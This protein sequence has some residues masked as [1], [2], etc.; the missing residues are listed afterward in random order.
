MAI[1]TIDT[2][3]KNSY[4]LK[5]FKSLLTLT[6]FIFLVFHT[7]E[8]LAYC[9]NDTSPTDQSIVLAVDIS[10][11]VDNHEMEMQMQAYEH[12]IKDP[13][14]KDKLLTCGCTEVSVVFFASASH[15]V[16]KSKKIKT[17]S[18]ISVI[19][20]LFSREKD[21]AAQLLQIYNDKGETYVTRALRASLDILIDDKNTSFRKAI[22]ISG[23]GANSR[24]ADEEFKALKKKSLLHGIEVSAVPIMIYDGPDFASPENDSNYSIL[25]RDHSTGS[26]SQFDHNSV[27]DFYQNMVVNKF[28]MMSVAD[29]YEDLKPVLSQSLKDISCKPM[30]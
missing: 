30:M 10:S 3:C 6:L 23:D 13:E 1:L 8:T 9:E 4:S 18:D 20:E 29:S 19:A 17:I 16:L 21:R 15:V 27:P 25:N 2:D 24:N 28:G 5:Q 11:S 22:L 7:D 12:A 14:V 26:I